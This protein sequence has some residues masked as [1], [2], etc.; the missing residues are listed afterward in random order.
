M[1][2]SVVYEKST[3]C[4]VICG[5]IDENGAELLSNHF[6]KLTAK[7]SVVKLILDFKSVAYIGSSGIGAIILFYKKLVQS[8]GNIQIRNVSKE[9]YDLLSDLDIN[10]IISI[11]SA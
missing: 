6:R 4:F 1:E 11:H 7:A 3:V 5:D 10:K 8:G 2:I 9:I